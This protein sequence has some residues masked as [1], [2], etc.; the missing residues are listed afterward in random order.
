[1]TTFVQLNRETA[2]LEYDDLPSDALISFDSRT[3]GSG[4]VNRETLGGGLTLAADEAL[5]RPRARTL[6]DKLT[7]YAVTPFDYEE[8][9]AVQK[10]AAAGA[11]TAADA[12]LV[13]TGASFT[14]ADVGK[15]VTIAGAGRSFTF[16]VGGATT[17]AAT[18]ASVTN[19]T[20]VELS[21]AAFTTVTA[22]DVL[23]GPCASGA[24]QDMID[25]A[26]ARATARQE[27]Q[28][29]LLPA[30]FTLLAD[31]QIDLEDY[32]SLQVEGNLIAANDDDE[33][34]L[35]RIRSDVDVAVFGHGT[36][37]ANF[38]GNCNA[39]GASGRS[40][41]GGAGYRLFIGGGLKIC[42]VRHG[43]AH[44]AALLSSV[45]DIG[46]GGG[47]G[48]SLQSGP[49]RNIVDGLF[50]ENADIGITYEGGT[51]NDAYTNGCL[52]SNVVVQGSEWA[53]LLLWGE[54]SADP[55]AEGTVSEISLSNV[56]LIDC[57]KPTTVTDGFAPIC[58]N[59]AY[60]VV[61]NVRVRNSTGRHDVWRGTARFCDLKINADMYELRHW[62]NH[63][64][65]GGYNTNASPSRHNHMH[66]P[67]KIRASCLVAGTG[68]TGYVVRADSG[69]SV[70]YGKYA[71][72]FTAHNGTDFLED[73]TIW[74]SGHVEPLENVARSTRFQIGC[75]SN[76]RLIESNTYI[77][78]SVANNAT[79]IFR[80]PVDYFT[81]LVAVHAGT[82]RQAVV[83][84]KTVGTPS[85]GAI[86]EHADFNLLTGT[87]SSASGSAGEFLVSTTN[88][89]TVMFVNRLGATVTFSAG[90]VGVSPL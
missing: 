86:S 40:D 80:P 39:I 68:I 11:I 78:R 18:I 21:A 19:A 14:S 37:D 7:D 58:S 26:T 10:F 71:V 70:A 52:I 53:G 84:C 35:V 45:S 50:I 20:T 51:S 57:G 34:G 60:G 89:G 17:H 24:I 64:F 75:Q 36:L 82:I 90:V 43:G 77:T 29:L 61:G 72:E 65:Y 5:G 63:E 47:K 62:V 59:A 4:K 16:S 33:G 55:V 8:L 28:L 30:G 79:V 87:I 27:K 44:L 22:G 81:L 12:T 56:N 38:I 73:F 46:R 67:L 2:G 88:A 13:V 9:A 48:V 23:V 25:W 15:R 42:N 49:R 54:F 85:I 69:Q 66:G 41:L 1:V 76:G 31:V 32:V 6:A 83:A 3:R 74:P